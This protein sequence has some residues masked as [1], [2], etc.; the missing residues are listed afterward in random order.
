MPNPKNYHK[1][2]S[3]SYNILFKKLWMLEDRKKTDSTNGCLSK[4]NDNF[5]FIFEPKQV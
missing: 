5:V 2:E 3:C 4:W 1:T